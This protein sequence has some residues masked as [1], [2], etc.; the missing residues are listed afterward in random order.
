L[1]T[2]PSRILVLSTILRALDGQ[3]PSGTAEFLDLPVE[4]RS[5]SDAFVPSLVQVAD[6]RVDDVSPLQALGDYILGGASV[7]QLADSGL[8]QP[9][10]PTDRR[11]RHAP[12]PTARGPYDDV[13]GVCR[14]P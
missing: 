10:L 11:L 8:V 5:V 12:G 7:H 3:L 13:T 4:L 6:V 1:A 9:E 14:R 2:A